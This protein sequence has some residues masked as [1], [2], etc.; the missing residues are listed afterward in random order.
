MHSPSPNN[1]SET[2]AHIASALRRRRDELK[3]SQEALALAAGLSRGRVNRIEQNLAD[4]VLVSTLGCLAGALQTDVRNLVDTHIVRLHRKVMQEPA[5]RVMGNVQHFR[6]KAGMSQED[7][8]IAS[9]YFRGY[10]NRLEGLRID[11][12]VSA[13]VAIARSLRVPLV[14]L[15]HP[16]KIDTL[17]QPTKARR[18]A[19]PRPA[20]NTSVE[21]MQV[22]ST[23]RSRREELGLSQDAAA[24]ACGLSRS[25]FVH[26]EQK[27]V[28]N[29]RLSTLVRLADGLGLDIRDLIDAGTKGRHH[30]NTQDPALR[31]ALNVLRLRKAKGLS[32]VDLS[33]QS[34]HFLRYI[35]TLEL[36]RA[37][38][39]IDSLR[40]IAEQLSVS[41]AEL[42]SPVP[43]S[44]YETLLAEHVG[45]QIG[46]VES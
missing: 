5:F 24:K 28:D 25:N 8:S 22:S 23:L 15:F 45:R 4:N 17:G 9:G 21:I 19:S 18:P 6:R 7:L 11:P 29:P 2:L 33:L 16:R 44:D 26:L 38:P 39:A 12:T 36:I 42:L 3:L 43:T 46:Q 20:R 40:R 10:I 14:D 34:G 30:P 37:D 41:S 13:L 35:N 27:T 31:L 1:V 32:Q